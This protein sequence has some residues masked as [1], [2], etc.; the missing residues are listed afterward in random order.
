MCTANQHSV[1]DIVLKMFYIL[2][3]LL[4]P[5]FSF[6]ATFGLFIPFKLLDI[7]SAEK[8]LT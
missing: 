2:V 8:N 4:R 6:L 3:C 7:S 1:N 5:K